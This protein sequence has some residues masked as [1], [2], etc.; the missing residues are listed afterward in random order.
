[1]TNQHITR[2]KMSSCILNIFLHSRLIVGPM[3]KSTLKI[4]PRSIL[5]LK[6]QKLSILIKSDTRFQLTRWSKPYSGYILIYLSKQYKVDNGENGL[7][8]DSAYPRCP[9]SS[10]HGL[11]HE[12]LSASVGLWLWWLESWNG[13]SY[14]ILSLSNL[15]TYA[16]FRCFALTQIHNELSCF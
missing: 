6:A 3:L 13:A 14:I 7:D 4:S 9:K 10:G 2:P 15:I 11:G 5:T 1:M 16:V 12:L 8:Y